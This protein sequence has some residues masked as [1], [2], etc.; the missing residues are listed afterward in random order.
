MDLGDA[1]FSFGRERGGRER[2]SEAR[3]TTNTAINYYRLPALLLIALFVLVVVIGLLFFAPA[4]KTVVISAWSQPSATPA[5]ASAALE[6]SST[7]PL[8][9]VLD[10]DLDNDGKVD[11][12]ADSL[13]LL[14]PQLVC[15]Y[16]ILGL[17]ALLTR[18]LLGGSTYLL[19]LYKEPKPNSVYYPPLERPG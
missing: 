10:N 19:A 7:V 12:R 5:K 16:A 1:G 6:A 17:I 9:A 14:A 2:S 8:K 18:P 4:P 13:P 11:G 3:L 15:V